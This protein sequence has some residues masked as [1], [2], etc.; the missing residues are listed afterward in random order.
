MFILIYDCLSQF[1]LIILS[2]LE[3]YQALMDTKD[4]LLIVCDGLDREL[5]IGMGDE[6]FVAFTRRL[7]VNADQISQWMHDERLRPREIGQNQLGFFLMWL[8]YEIK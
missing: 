6:E 4:A 2:V 1:L 5:G 8:R 3:F 7:R